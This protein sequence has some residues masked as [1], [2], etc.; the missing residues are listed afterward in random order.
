MDKPSKKTHRW[1]CEL[2]PK[3]GS[4]LF[5]NG[6]LTLMLDTE[7]CVIDLV[8]KKVI[9]L[10]EEVEEGEFYIQQ[11]VKQADEKGWDLPKLRICHVNNL[12]EYLDSKS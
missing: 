4:V 8:E 2:I 11:S 9:A 12:V 7:Q 5:S 10:F 6:T 1:L 3:K